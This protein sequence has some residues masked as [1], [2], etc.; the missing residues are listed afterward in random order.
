MAKNV[1]K[2][3]TEAVVEA[4][5][6][7][8]LFFKKYK[9]VLI[10]GAV[11]LVAVAF[12]VFAYQKW[13]IQ[14]K[15][16]EAQQQVFPAEMAFKAESWETALNGDGNNLGFADVISEYGKAAPAATWFQAGVCALQ[17]GNFEEAVDYLSAY[18]GK[19]GILEARAKACLGDAYVGLEKYE[20]AYD[21][22]LK[23]AAVVDN[24]YAAAYL[25]KAGVT[26]EQLGKTDNALKCYK[27]IKEKY[28]NSIEGYDIDKYITRLAK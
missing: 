28:P 20:Q 3:N 18:R 24:M 23:A 4:V 19:D 6:K 15:Q 25:L 21:C 26:A 17:L 14:P 16:R 8:D 12:A 13:Y 5:S 7:T 27:E 22:F 11:A 10:W 1:K 9:N 2:E